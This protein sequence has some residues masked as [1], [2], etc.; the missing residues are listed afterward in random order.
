MCKDIWNVLIAA[1]GKSTVSRTQVPLWYNQFK[2]GQ[3]DVNDYVRLDR[4]SMSTTDETIKAVEKMI[5]DNRWIT[6]RG[7]IM[8]A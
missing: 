6:I 5:L 4:P 2:K 7:L 1:F 3:E 8:L